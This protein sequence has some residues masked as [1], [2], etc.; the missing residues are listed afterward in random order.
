[1]G[2]GP[3]QF[4]S[5]LAATSWAVLAGIPVGIIAL[6]FLKLR[7][8]PVQVPST[9][10]WRRS[11]ED[12]HV[13]SL[14][15]RLRKNL[16]LF[17]QLLAV[18]LVMLALAGPRIRGTTGQGERFVLAI[19]NS[20][21]MAATDVEPT[22][23]EKA[24]AEARKVVNAMRSDDLAMVISFSDR[25]RVVSNYTGNRNLL[26]QRIDSIRPTETTTSLREALQVAAG[27]ANP[28]KQAEGVAATA[29][30]VPPKL[31]IYTD[32]GFPDVEGFSLGNLEP[33]VIVIGT[34]PPAP[35][36]D[37]D[38]RGQGRGPRPAGLEQRRDPRPPDPPERGEAR[39]LP[40]LRP[41][42]QLQGRGGRHRGQAVQ[43]RP[44]QARRAREAGR[45]HLAPGRQ[46]GRPVVQLRPARHRR[47]RAGSPPR[48]QGRPAARQPG[49][50]PHR[51]P[52]EGP[53]PRRHRRATATSSTPSGP[54]WP[55]TGPT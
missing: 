12:L 39:R 13:N 45:R 6:Y 18:F 1:M 40:G 41:G 31:K 36:E 32:G 17:L 21:S 46:A 5:P 48:R 47:D 37:A 29:N 22:R 34:A 43:A 19:D 50:H 52:A 2:I 33:E 25:A 44:R 35:A 42:P 11:M 38:R 10:L 16:L 23:L 15:Q 30:I 28:S 54:P 3:V 53:D 51:R 27:L 8:R 49:L 4:I 9:L 26:S 24:K 20:A 14:F 7:R 55:P